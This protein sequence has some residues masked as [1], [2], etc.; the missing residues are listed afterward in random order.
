MQGR[1]EDNKHMHTQ[2]TGTWLLPYIF[3]SA[4][5][6]IRVTPGVKRIEL[7]RSR[8]LA[9]HYCN[10]MIQQ[11]NPVS[12]CLSSMISCSLLQLCLCPPILVSKLKD[13]KVHEKEPGAHELDFDFAAS[14]V[15]LNSLPASSLPE[16]AALPR[17][18]NS[19]EA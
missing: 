3:G 5:C 12:V 7:C 2:H 18:H 17:L 15:L 11:S 19:Q 13:A 4:I 10:C 8:V 16:S 9:Q 6:Q 14:L 1:K